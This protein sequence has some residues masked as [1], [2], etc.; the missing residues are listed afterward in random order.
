MPAR[1]DAATSVLRN[2]GSGCFTITKKLWWAENLM[3][4][5]MQSVRFPFATAFEICIGGRAADARQLSEKGRV[6]FEVPEFNGN[7]VG[8]L[9]TEFAGQ[10]Q[11]H[12]HDGHRGMRNTHLSKEGKSQ[13]RKQK[14]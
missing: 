1:E 10:L 12:H 2:H 5:S 14:H 4:G 11:P 13:S 7:L 3:A 6:R 9:G 8:V